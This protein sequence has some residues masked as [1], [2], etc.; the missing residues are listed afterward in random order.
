MIED[1]LIYAGLACSNIIYIIL[2]E[3]DWNANQMIP[4]KS[5]GV[6]LSHYALHIDK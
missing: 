3:R 1:I 2:S 4:E 5:Q 6:P